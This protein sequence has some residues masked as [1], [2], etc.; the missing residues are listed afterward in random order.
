M[1]VEMWEV[2]ASMRDDGQECEPQPAEG[3]GVWGF[4]PMPARIGSTRCGRAHRPG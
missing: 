3:P 4:D 1:F 2:T